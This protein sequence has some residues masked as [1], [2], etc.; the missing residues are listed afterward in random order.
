[1]V[2]QCDR[3][4]YKIVCDVDQK[5]QSARICRHW[6]NCIHKSEKCIGGGGG[7][8]TRNFAK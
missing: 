1:M 4:G 8:E 6:A 3:T 7:V 2:T 5:R